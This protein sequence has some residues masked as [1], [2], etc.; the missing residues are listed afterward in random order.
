VEGVDS[1]PIRILH[2]SDLHIGE[3]S[4]TKRPKHILL[5]EDSPPNIL[6][7]RIKKVVEEHEDEF[8]ADFLV[9]TGDIISQ[10]KTKE[11]RQKRYKAAGEQLD[12]LWRAIG[13]PDKRQVLIVP[14]NHDVLSPKTEPGIDNITRLNDYIDFLEHFYDG[15][16]KNENPSI[17]SLETKKITVKKGKDS[18]E[19]NIVQVNKNPWC[20]R[21]EKGVVFW[22]LV[23]C[24]FTDHEHNSDGVCCN[25]Q[26][27]QGEK[28]LS[29]I[30]DRGNM[31]CIVISHHNFLPGSG[32]MVKNNRKG[33][34]NRAM[35]ALKF[36]FKYGVLIVLHGHRH[37]DHVISFGEWESKKSGYKSERLLLGAPSIGYY[38]EGHESEHDLAGFAMIDLF[39]QP[40]TTNVELK[41]YRLLQRQNGEWYSHSPDVRIR[42]LRRR[43]GLQQFM[44]FPEGYKKF[45]ADILNGDSLTKR[46]IILHYHDDT[47]WHDAFQQ[48][49][50]LNINDDLTG[51]IRNTLNKW[52]S[53][54]GHSLLEEGYL[55]ENLITVINRSKLHIEVMKIAT[56]MED[57]N[58]VK[59][60]YFLT[61]LSKLKNKTT[62]GE[63]LVTY[64]A[65]A[66]Y[67]AVNQQVDFRKHVYFSPSKTKHEE[68]RNKFIWL[69]ETIM[70]ARELENFTISW[71]PF[72]IADYQGKSL[73]GI[74][75]DD[76]SGQYGET[77]YVGFDSETSRHQKSVLRLPRKVDKHSE[78]GPILNDIK[79]L[80]RKVINP[81]SQLL[82][83][84]FLIFR[85]GKIYKNNLYCVAAVIGV[86]DV[87]EEDVGKRFARIFK[88]R[89]NM[90]R[91]KRINISRLNNLN[92]WVVKKNAKAWHVPWAKEDNESM[93]LS[94]R[95]EIKHG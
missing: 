66:M 51:P 15:I 41:K 31:C 1:K 14:G 82:V 68:M 33:Y 64:I 72:S 21:Y 59:N 79:A 91:P 85:K 71:L 75:G 62:E 34:S 13:I 73:V 78:E 95:E 27:N 6:A 86:K 48:F 83:N 39:H 22:P 11:E 32:V 80:M 84:D 54:F 60:D 5:R 17:L 93:L 24:D 88:M 52:L 35:E 30:S 45:A 77:F 61:Y 7:E 56:G 47:K 25:H 81:L 92:S 42:T 76:E 40:E 63:R 53:P 16:P 3:I 58:D 46:V 26:L 90:W 55:N 28:C 67:C 57:A 70:L 65:E 49:W 8:S 43:E 20:V 74:H 4:S 89:P 10:A 36:M 19:K 9:V 18:Y 23:T 50:R 87:W 29:E 44:T 94:L 2:I 12:T 37:Q 38:E 69:L